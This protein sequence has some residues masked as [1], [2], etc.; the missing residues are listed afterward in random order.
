MLFRSTLN[1][2]REATGERWT[3]SN[4]PIAADLLGNLLKR[5]SAGE[6]T[7]KS[8]REVLTHLLTAAD[9]REPLTAKTIDEIITT[10]N[11]K[12]ISDTNT[13]DPAL[14]A[15]IAESAQAVADYRNGKQQ[16]LGAMIGKVMKQLKG[17]DAARV[18][19]RLIEKLR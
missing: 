11:L 15:V 14:D 4:F 16:A 2:P 6:L 10:K 17:A 7:V 13:L 18:R 9:S 5:V 3:I 1:S 8:G 12:I 19:A